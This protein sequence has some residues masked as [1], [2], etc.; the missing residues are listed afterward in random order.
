IRDGGMI[1]AWL[2]L[3]FTLVNIIGSVAGLASQ[4]IGG[5]HL[6]NV[7]KVNTQQVGYATLAVSFIFLLIYLK[8]FSCL[9]TIVTRRRPKPIH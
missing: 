8:L 4:L 1:S 2:M 7:G 6:A 9:C 3:L 5:S